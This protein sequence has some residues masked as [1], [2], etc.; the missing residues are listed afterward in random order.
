MDFLKLHFSYYKKDVRFE[1]Q[2]IQIR[3]KTS[4][5]AISL[6][7]ATEWIVKLATTVEKK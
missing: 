2:N 7:K 1:G 6:E 3:H 4:S 5:S